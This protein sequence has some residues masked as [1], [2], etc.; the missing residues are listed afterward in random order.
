MPEFNSIVSEEI[1]GSPTI[2]QIPLEQPKSEPLNYQVPKSSVSFERHMPTR[3]ESSNPLGDF[4]TKFNSQ[5]VDLSQQIRDI[6][7]NAE[8]V[9]LKR[10]MNNSNFKELGIELDDSNE[11]RYGANQSLGD[12][13]SNGF[14]GMRKLAAV[15]FVDTWKQF[16]RTV[17]ALRSWD[18]NKLHG[19]AA[20]M[21]ELDNEI[22]DIMD[23]SAIY[24][25]KQGTD[26]F[27]NRET[28][29]NF[30][31]QS[32]F[33][34]GA[35]LSMAAEHLVTKAIEAG[36]VTTGVGAPA[37]GAIEGAVDVQTAATVGRLARVMNR[38]KEFFDAAK[39]FKALKRLGDLWKEDKLISSFIEG[40]GKKLPGIDIAVDMNQVWKAGK[41]A[42]ISGGE[43]A[44][45]LTKVG[46]GGVKRL[47]SESNFAFS[48]ARMEAAGTYSDLYSK[49]Q[50]DY[51][52]TY[53]VPASEEQLKKMSSISMEAA[54]KNFNFNAAVLAIS[55]RIAFDSI[56]KNSKVALNILAKYGLDGAIEGR[57]AVK[58]IL[59]ETERKATQFYTKG[60]LG[61]IGQL[62]KVAEDFGTKKALQVGAG[63]VLS[64]ITK[65]QTLEGVQ[66]LLQEGSNVYFQDYYSKAY[67][68][69]IN[70]NYKPELGTSLDKAIDSQLN[71][72]GLKTF[73]SGAL[74]GLILHGPTALGGR[75]LKYGNEKIVDYNKTKNLSAEEKIKYQENKVAAKE[76]VKEYYNTFN[77]YAKDPSTFFSEAI[78]NLNLQKEGTTVLDEAAKLGDKFSYENLRTDTL[79]GFIAASIRNN[80]HEALLDTLKAYGDNFSKEEFE[81][82]FVG[83][84]YSSEN[85]KTASDYTSKVIGSVESYIKTWNKLQD[86]YGNRANPNRFKYGTKEWFNEA[87]RKKTLNDVI[88]LLAGNEAK[89]VNALD[90]VTSIFQ[91]VSSNKA[92]GTSLNSAFQILGSETNLENEINTLTAEIKLNK[93]QLSAEGINAEDKK[94]IQQ[95][96][97]L[98][99]TQLDYLKNWKD[100]NEEM[101]RQRTVNY[102]LAASNAFKGYLQSKNKQAG[103]DITINDK[104]VDDHFLDLVD[105]IKLN[106]KSKQYINAIN[107]ITDE[108]NFTALHD[109]MTNGASRAYFELLGQAGI[110]HIKN[111]TA[112]NESFILSIHDTHSLYDKDGNLIDVYDTLEDATAAKEQ[113][114]TEEEV[115]EE[116]IEDEIETEQ[117]KEDG[118]KEPVQKKKTKKNK[119]EESEET[120]EDQTDLV[121]EQGT[122]DPEMSYVNNHFGIAPKKIN[123]K[124]KYADNGQIA[125]ATW[126][127]VGSKEAPNVEKS[128]NTIADLENILRLKSLMDYLTKVQKIY[129]VAITDTEVLGDSKRK[130]YIYTGFIPK[131]FNKTEELPFFYSIL[132]E[133]DKENFDDGFYTDDN[134]DLLE[135]SKKDLDE[136]TMIKKA[137]I[138]EILNSIRAEIAKQTAAMKEVRTVDQKFITSATN[139]VKMFT[140]KDETMGNM[141]EVVFSMSK[142]EIKNKMTGT[143]EKIKPGEPQVVFDKTRNKVRLKVYRQ[144]PVVASTVLVNDKPIGYPTH[145][146]VYIFEIDGVKK[147]SNELT[148]KEFY[149]FAQDTVSYEEYMSNYNTSM[150]VYTAF[151]ELLGDKK[152]VKVSNEELQK[153]FDITPVFGNY[154]FSKAK[155]ALS[156]FEK[157]G[158]KLLGVVDKNNV[159]EA[160][161]PGKSLTEVTDN[162]SEINKH[163]TSLEVDPATGAIKRF[164]NQGR[165]IAVF[166]LPNG[167][168]AFVEVTSAN[169]DEDGLDTVYSEL[170]SRLQK[171]FKENV[172]L[173]SDGKI[174]EVK[175]K[176]FNRGFDT[177]T[178]DSGRTPFYI[179]IPQNPQ[180]PDAL[181]YNVTITVTANGS[182]VVQFVNTQSKDVEYHK[183]YIEVK[184]DEKGNPDI[185][186]FTDMLAKIN[187][188]IV[189]YNSE[190]KE[191]ELPILKPEYFKESI[192]KAAKFSDMAKQV[193]NVTEDIFQNTHIIFTQSSIATPDVD[194]SS[195]KTGKNTGKK[196]EV[197]ITPVST[198]SKADIEKEKAS[199]TPSEFAELKRL[200]KFFLENPK[201]PIVKGS[202]VTRYPT[203][204]KVLTDIERR[205]EE[206]LDKT[207]A[208]I[209]RVE[210]RGDSFIRTKVEVYTTLSSNETLDEIII[211]TFKDGSRIFRTTDVKTGELILDEKIKKDNSTTNEKF[212]EEWVGNLDN[213]L[214]KISEDNNPNKTVVD[215][216]NAKYDAELAALEGGKPTNQSDV[217]T[218]YHHT[219]VA[220]KDF[221]FGNFQRGKQQVSQFGDGLNASSTTTPFLVK[222]YGNPIEGEIR[223]SDF[224]VIDAN[225]SEKELYEELKAKGYKFNNP[226]TGSYIGKDPAKEYDGT[227]KANEQPSIISLFNDFQKSNPQVK[228]VK[229]INH[230]IGDEKVDPFYVIYD[231]TSFYGPGSLSKTQ[232]SSTAEEPVKKKRGG[233]GLS[234]LKVDVNAARRQAASENT[235]DED[236]ASGKVATNSQNKT[237]QEIQD[238][239]SIDKNK[240]EEKFQKDRDIVEY[241]KELTKLE[242]QFNKDMEPFVS[243]RRIN[244]TK[245]SDTEDFTDASVEDIDKF[246]SWMKKVLSN[247]DV[248]ADTL[249][250]N[251]ANNKVIVGK[252]IAYVKMTSNGPVISGSIQTS[253]EAAF[254]YHEAFHAVFTL[255]LNDEQIDKLLSLARYQVVNKL[256]TEGKN[257]S[258]EVEKMRSTHPMYAEM[259]KEQLTERYLE[260]HLADEFDKFKMNQSTP[261][262]LAKIR[263]LFAKL[264]DFINSL[265]GRQ[266]EL[267]TFYKSI[268]KGKF[269]NVNVQSNKFTRELALVN[270]PV[271]EKFKIRYG[272]KQI[273]TLTGE[274][275]MT[276]RY[277]NE[278]DTQRI[279]GSVVNSFIHRVENMPEYNKARVLDGILLDMM[280]LYQIGPKYAT[281]SIDKINRLRM[282]KD[283]FNSNDAKEDI[284]KNV[285]VFLELMGYTQDLEDDMEYE[286]AIED[287]GDRATTEKFGEKFAH[288]GFKSFSKYARQY[289]QSTT[290]EKQDEFGNQF[291]DEET[292]EPLAFG[293]NSGVIYNGMV[294]LMSGVTTEDKFKQRL[295][296]FRNAASEQ[297]VAFI[298]KFLDDTGISEES[299]WEPIKNKELFNAIYKPFTLFNVSYRSYLID[300]KTGKSKSIRANMR[301]AASNQYNQWQNDFN[302]NYQD[303]WSKAKQDRVLELMTSIN[304][305]LK[306]EFEISDEEFA[307]KAKQL[308]ELEGLSG[309]KIV[310]E[311]Y[312]YSALSTLRENFKKQASPLTKD[313]IDFVKSFEGIPVLLSEDI[314]EI[315]K[316]IAKKE[317]PFITF[318]DVQVDTTPAGSDE[319]DNFD[320]DADEPEEDVSEEQKADEAVKYEK[321]MNKGN[322]SRLMRIA[323]GNSLFD[324]TVLSSSWLNSEFE[325][326]SSHQLPNFHLTYLEDVIKNPI[327]LERLITEDPYLMDS[328]IGQQILNNGEFRQALNRLR[329]DRIDGITARRLTQLEDGT[330]LANSKLQVNKRDGITYGKFNDREF[331]LTNILMYLE[332]Q[333]T[334]RKAGGEEIISTRHLIRVI[335]SKSTGDTINMPVI[336]TVIGKGNKVKLSEEASKIWLQEF[337]AEFNRINRV[338]ADRNNPEKDILDNYNDFD[339]PKS[340][341]RGVKFRTFEDILGPKKS[342]EYRNLAMSD[343]PTLNTR[344]KEEIVNLVQDYLLGDPKTDN[345]GL[346]DEY[347]YMLDDAGIVKVTDKG[348]INVMLP[349]EIFGNKMKNPTDR[350]NKGY[351]GTDFRANIAQFFINDYLNT[352]SIN[353]LYYGDQSMSLVD[354]VDAVKRAAGAIGSGNNMATS[355][356]EENLG[357]THSHQNSHVVTHVDPVYK[358]QYSKSEKQKWADAQ[359]WSTVKTARY[360]SFGLGR[361]NKYKAEIFDKLERG[362]PLTAEEVF[363]INGTIEN[364]AQLKVEKLVYFDGRKY[365]KTS[366]FFLTKELTSQLKLSAKRRIDALLAKAAE[367]KITEKDYLEQVYAIQ[368][369][370][371]N[372]IARPGREILH[373][374]R[375]E[376]EKFQDEN[377]TTVYS[378]PVS[379]SK[380][381][382]KNVSQSLEDFNISQNQAYKIDNRYMR[383]QLENTTNKKGGI[384][385][386][387]QMQNIIDAEQNPN[388]KVIFKGKEGVKIKDV[389]KEFQ[390]AI[391]QKAKLSYLLARNNIFSF[392]DITNEYEISVKA[393]EIT[394]KLA[395][396]QKKALENLKK[397]GASQQLLEFFEL[398]KDS[399]TGEESP[400]YDLNSPYTRKKYEQLFLSYFRR[401]ILQQRTPGQALTLTS[402][403]GAEPLKRAKRILD[404]KVV[405]WEVV[406]VDQQEASGKEYRP[407]S[408]REKVANKVGVKEEYVMS[409]TGRQRIYLSPAMNDY[410]FF[411]KTIDDVTEVGQ[412]FVDRLR[413]NIPVYD[414]SENII[415][416]KT[417]FMMPHHFRETMEIGAQSELPK[418]IVD[419]FAARIPGQD[420][421]SAC[422]LDLVDFLPAHYGSMGM[423]AR[424][425]A[426]ISGADNDVDKGYTQF[427][428]FYVKRNKEGEAE[429][430]KYGTATSDVDRF[431]EFFLWNIANNKILGSEIR[432]IKEKDEDYAK[433]K[434]LL[435]KLYIAKEHIL[436][437]KK[438]SVEYLEELNQIDTAISFL[439][440][441]DTLDEPADELSDD[442]LLNEYNKVKGRTAEFIKEKILHLDGLISD[443]SAEII[444]S[445]TNI[446]VVK[447]RINQVKREKVFLE[448]IIQME[449]MENLHLPTDVET[450]LDFEYDMDGEVNIGA[451]NNTILEAKRTLLSNEYMQEDSKAFEVA[452]QGVLEDLEKDSDIA[453]YLNPDSTI[454]NDNQVGKTLSQLNNKE[455]S[456][457]IG[458][459]VNGQMAN[460]F[461]MKNT[462]RFR[463]KDPEKANQVYILKIDDTEFDSYEHERKA[464]ITDDNEVIPKFNSKS[465]RRIMNA[466]S[467]YVSAMTDNAK[468][469]RSAKFGL[470]INAAGIAM[471]LNGRGVPDKLIAA[472]MLNKTVQKY[473]NAVKKEK[474]AITK[475]EKRTSKK[476]IAAEMMQRLIKKAGG[477]KAEIKPLTTTMLLDGL[478]N[479]TAETNLSIFHHFLNI[480]KQSEAFSTLSQV[481]KLTKGP[482]ADMNDWDDLVEKAHNHLGIGLTEEQ[483]Q[484]SDIPFDVRKL[485]LE[486]SPIISTYW[487]INEQIHNE[488]GKTVLISRSKLFKTTKNALLNQLDVEYA[489]LDKVEG[490]LENNLIMYFALRAYVKT[491]R[492]YDDELLTLLD[493]NLV[494]GT[495]KESETITDII[496]EARIN[497]PNNYLI[498]KYL[499]LVP[500]TVMQGGKEILN[501][502][503]KKKIHILEP[504]SYG[505]IDPHMLSKIQDSFMDLYEND[506]KTALAIF[507]YSIV[508][509]ATLF[510]PNGIMHIFPSFM[511]KELMGDVMFGVG[512][513]FKNDNLE[514][515]LSQGKKSKDFSDMFDGTFKQVI[516]DFME[517]YLRHVENKFHLKEI[518]LKSPEPVKKDVKKPKDLPIRFTVDE[519][520][521]IDRKQIIINIFTGVTPSKIKYKKKK[522]Q[523]NPEDDEE[524][525]IEEASSSKYKLDKKALEQLKNN[526]KILKDDDYKIFTTSDD[527]GNIGLQLP[528]SFKVKVGRNFN[529]Y[530]L[531]NISKISDQEKMQNVSLSDVLT[532]KFNI[533][534]PSAIYKLVETEGAY[535]VTPIGNV[536][537]D[538]P[539]Y[540]EINNP[541]LLI[542][543]KKRLEETPTEKVEEDEEE[544]DLDISSPD[545]PLRRPSNEEEEEDE[546]PVAQ[547]RDVAFLKSKGISVSLK[548]GEYVYKKNGKEYKF[549]GS[550]RELADF[551][552]EDGS[553]NEKITGKKV[554][555][556][557]EI[558]SG[559]K[560]FYDP[561][562]APGG[563]KGKKTGYIPKVSKLERIEDEDI[564]QKMVDKILE[565]E[566]Q[567]ITHYDGKKFVKFIGTKF[568]QYGTYKTKIE[569]QSA[570]S[571]IKSGI[572]TEVNVGFKDTLRDI[573]ELFVMEDIEKKSPTFGEQIL[574]RAITAPYKSNK[575]SFNKNQGWDSSVWE[576]RKG[577]INKYNELSF[578]FE[579]VG[580]IVDDQLVLPEEKPETPGIKKVAT[581]SKTKEAKETKKE[582][583]TKLPQSAFKNDT[584]V[585]KAGSIQETITNRLK[586]VMSESALAGGYLKKEQYKSKRAT[587]YIGEGAVNNKGEDSSTE[588]FRKLYD[589]YDIAN[590]GD[591]TSDDMIWVSTN[592]RRSGRI[593][594]VVDGKLQG[595]YKNITAAIKAGASFIMDTAEHIDSSNYNL[596]EVEMA[597]YLTKKGYVRDDKTGIWTPKSTPK[598]KSEEIPPVKKFSLGLSNLKLDINAARKQAAKENT[599]VDDKTNKFAPGT[600]EEADK[601]D[602]NKKK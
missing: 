152:S 47:I 412:L 109:R 409:P 54:D 572:K 210:K 306:G 477:E 298:N 116:E 315:M 191:A 329:I 527:N 505:L 548:G 42:G 242:K 375:V 120:L 354:F 470:N 364:N 238:Q 256:K 386:S 294:K 311:Y 277:V 380:M 345:P 190:T 134:T 110:E 520:G 378:I 8:S 465:T 510:S 523:D 22:K 301:D 537:G 399:E 102:S 205:R 100:A 598:E 349:A 551:F 309:I 18:W 186:N 322:R 502:D 304:D 147:T 358:G 582:T 76:A 411:H 337:M 480:E 194:A 73:M 589:E 144:S 583:P 464:V 24:A 241:D 164:S 562:Y 262:L 265:L 28:A 517:G 174:S 441:V 342:E 124:I 379:A 493:N 12:A 197:I 508:K 279:V 348:I 319:D 30:L 57:L 90:R 564:T 139:V 51:I 44:W 4:L 308:K 459:V 476:K 83:I 156:E 432:D 252:F 237:V 323:E 514:E 86:R 148:K 108:K 6:G 284:K 542:E 525:N 129:K 207:N 140:M 196:K 195:K 99:E 473:Y 549:D 75:A 332:D 536:F 9:G 585:P 43:I 281:L 178:E 422:S 601:I 212:I 592:G 481:L 596:G 297:T 450:F 192:P 387:T 219:S 131:I 539:L 276:P 395:K 36:L 588:T 468:D 46:V 428:D 74:T 261:G 29:G 534:A 599:D 19:D 367:S 554:V 359:T 440:K 362:V 232:I 282:F 426:E 408:D 70:P 461:L 600:Q 579:Y 213:S 183:A 91:K 82:A 466:G 501:K 330:V 376:M 333:E 40:V 312:K 458:S 34:V 511:F 17:D 439:S 175:N 565:E 202:V 509:D 169:L 14:T 435:D 388:A 491:L 419:Y 377:A 16:G 584:F 326:V 117:K 231:A 223:D 278:S 149:L 512:K 469:R 361:L 436:K 230:I 181:S 522:A 1:F 594:P 126:S 500:T 535:G 218:V 515:Y 366:V 60:R 13:I 288:G 423:F 201:E 114:D 486:S 158:I 106:D 410:E 546:E 127:F 204:F 341:L 569:G 391:A 235:A 305:G 516:S 159:A 97:E 229:V 420:K 402:D 506:R 415:G 327:A 163:I 563:T 88:E 574:L 113:F 224:I 244:K 568:N 248:D 209:E 170:A 141:K 454:D 296:H 253:A 11:A 168:P 350:M 566:T 344:Q 26:T 243:K 38:S 438:S 495:N 351:L 371:N 182:L 317:S 381:T 581:V 557:K 272:Y 318:D 444:T 283:I 118:K 336:S 266:S 228:G 365:I 328:Y 227:E 55:N 67:Q 27:W 368:R 573:N 270:N 85:K 398:D 531:Q 58:G 416:Y 111:N 79:N 274:I 430:V 369:D 87:T 5:P 136:E 507:A 451:L 518:K 72:Q 254:K 96:L 384:N 519:T 157:N 357:I 240:L 133:D 529:V 483:F 81:K 199:V 449:A 530:V 135:K 208:Q 215:K 200:A 64:N 263:E 225:K 545:K 335:E 307:K 59:K 417:E 360:N 467:G 132:S 593:A 567:P 226:A 489:L 403:W 103:K 121:E 383:L 413:H 165:Y 166:T 290:Y 171:T 66:E 474:Y 146:D 320:S 544:S 494:Y 257:L 128:V 151:A 424:E 487:K 559:V 521:K 173:E 401:D 490:K 352:I 137:A 214:K 246:R 558:K 239:Y 93:S 3:T 45:D 571:L 69:S 339:N 404:G 48:E 321:Q 347:I 172:L 23:E 177:F 259:T 462:V 570:I 310:F 50:A 37:A 258:E 184:Y 249:A 314:S 234:G 32:G 445:K 406:R 15:G 597:S 334:M 374:K 68:A 421:H 155:T 460:T 595:E 41:A 150:A 455:G 71:M 33:A 56:F 123:Y 414:E 2:N 503:N 89:A 302:N 84:E 142:D 540:N 447:K 555:N 591:Y 115:P 293:V 187:T 180:K 125:Y 393:G 63:S 162:R 397:T 576:G 233:L 475:N 286:N 112:S 429:F 122:F 222:R 442:Y 547:K 498:K 211:I 185:E 292:Q 472:L 437:Y 553:F 143:V 434:T 104:D 485:V 363:G 382:K 189:N 526:I 390:N 484:R 452:D 478:S 220:P 206:E 325:T 355:L 343:N 268:D 556:K 77:A 550:P 138:S 385:D 7:F 431:V 105:Y 488:I 396:F 160:I 193:T 587:Q 94:K 179:A 35:G 221:N 31:Q 153:I 167:H 251:L 267:K 291:L 356:I 273:E 324:E 533:V 346:V 119:P 203:L 255:F 389:I 52:N 316:T 161:V 62:G 98:K 275:I 405:E 250:E 532:D 513:I 433:V 236:K 95:Q 264:L 80:T 176:N 552:D 499:R 299:G 561:A 338:W 590:T 49:L 247:I 577:M 245:I 216:I 285:N 295:L 92:L 538:V 21:I 456:R 145:P 524:S 300:P 107:F 492:T 586:D 471:D 331:L 463:R 188:E 575:A 448:R 496:K 313:Q 580:D 65:F 280:K 392:E 10:Y 407:M 541:E 101:V 269:N 217:V 198:D 457:N 287:E 543:E 446:A 260:E 427:T 425:M 370:N 602:C 130:Y 453:P 528:Y 154:T 78:K 271:I 400:A 25:T 289:I 353:K 578:R 479:P 482:T 340:Q 303:N 39:N 560:K 394:A 443:I 61:T 20:S 372:W 373:N 497:N 418:A 53:G 504:S